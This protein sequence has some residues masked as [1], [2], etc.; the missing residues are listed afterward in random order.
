MTF[1][2]I[3][4][5]EK[6]P[7]YSLYFGRIEGFYDRSTDIDIYYH[8]VLTSLYLKK[9]D[10]KYG[11]NMCSGERLTKLC[12]YEKNCEE[13][14]FEEIYAYEYEAL[15]TFLRVAETYKFETH[16]YMLDENMEWPEGE[17]SDKVVI[18]EVLKECEKVDDAWKDIVQECAEILATNFFSLEDG[19][20]VLLRNREIGLYK[21][22]CL[23][24]KDFLNI[25]MKAEMEEIEKAIDELEFPLLY[26]N[27]SECGYVDKY[28]Y[29]CVTS[30]FDGYGCTSFAL[31]NTSWLIYCFIL[32]QLLL[33]FRKKLA[34]LLANERSTR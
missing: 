29:I 25:H 31:L 18:K 28:Y 32:N 15:E 19:T 30:G 26:Y 1:E 12:C 23:R 6:G 21:E 4:R 9:F 3:K 20:I 14:V 17:D 13:L 27:V 16:I 33:D 8:M 11:T 2:E 24:Y 34:K 5:I 7:D 22:I 10:E